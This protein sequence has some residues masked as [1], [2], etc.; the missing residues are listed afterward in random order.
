MRRQA[1][2]KHVLHYDRRDMAAMA[3][4]LRSRATIRR[5]WFST[6]RRKIVRGLRAPAQPVSR[7]EP[8]RLSKWKAS[9]HGHYMPMMIN[10][11]LAARGSLGQSKCVPSL[12]GPQ[13]ARKNLGALELLLLLPAIT[14]GIAKL[15][16]E[17]WAGGGCVG[18]HKPGESLPGTLAV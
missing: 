6:F 13:E 9:V 2:G 12:S 17:A 16:S 3:Y 1:L 10:R 15:R 11:L 7:W 5:T 4:L 8:C 18:N 14:I